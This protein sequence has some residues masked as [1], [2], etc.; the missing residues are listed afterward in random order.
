MDF[1]KPVSFCHLLNTKHKAVNHKHR[2]PEES[3]LL[4]IISCEFYLLLGRREGGKIPVSRSIQFHDYSRTV[5]QQTYLG[6]NS[7][8]ICIKRLEDTTPNL[9][10][11]LSLYHS[12]NRKEF[13]SR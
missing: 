12:Y 10:I 7:G 5:L 4:G 11:S 2:E 8:Y 13:K 9:N 1:S 6:Q 3:N